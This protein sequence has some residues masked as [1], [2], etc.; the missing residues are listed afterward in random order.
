MGACPPKTIYPKYY[1]FLDLK[2]LAKFQNPRTTPSVHFLCFSQ[3]NE[4]PSPRGQRG[5]PNVFYPKSSFFC[6]LTLCAKFQNPR[7]THSGSK[8]CGTEKQERKNNNKNNVHF[9]PLQR[10]RAVHRPKYINV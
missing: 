7:T 6:D 8:V 5:S 2:L 9:V 10:L 1:F 3:K 4:N